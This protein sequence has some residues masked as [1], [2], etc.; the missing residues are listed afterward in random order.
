MLFVTLVFHILLTNNFLFPQVLFLKSGDLRNA[1][2]T[3]AQLPETYQNLIVHPADTNNESVARNTL[4][5]HITFSTD[6]DASNPIDLNY[7]WDVWHSF[8]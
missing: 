3:A 6:F 8:K 7:L 2:T 5:S 1:L 4:L